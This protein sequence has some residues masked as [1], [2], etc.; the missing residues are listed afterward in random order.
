ME[1][2]NRNESKWSIGAKI[3][4]AFVIFCQ[5][6]MFIEYYT[7]PARAAFQNELMIWGIVGIIGTVLYLW[8]AFGKSK[9]ALNII[10]AI[11]VINVIFGFSQ[12]AGLASL[13]ALILPGITYLIAHKKVS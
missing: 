10:V 9:A 7:R 6:I 8:L 5:W 2:E 3:W 13:L 12:G 11:G 4:F 1:N